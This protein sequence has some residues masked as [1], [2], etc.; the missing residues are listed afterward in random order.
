MKNAKRDQ[1]PVR[2][3]QDDVRYS[4]NLVELFLQEF[5]SAGDIVFDPF[6]SPFRPPVLTATADQP[7]T[8]T[9]KAVAEIVA[10][11]VLPSGPFDLRAKLNTHEK[12]LITHALGLHK[13]NQRSTARHLHLSY[14]QLRHAMKK[15]TLL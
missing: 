1:L 6:D 12:T 4:E 3:R 8:Q 11:T 9:D 5:T 15:H 10:E 2:F 7:S 14:D 13:F